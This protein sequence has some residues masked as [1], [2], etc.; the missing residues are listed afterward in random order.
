M[1]ECNLSNSEKI[2]EALE[3]S[4]INRLDGQKID[5]EAV[6]NQ[7]FINS[8][9]WVCDKE[10]LA[11]MLDEG[12]GTIIFGHAENQADFLHLFDKIIL[13][14]CAP[15][16]FLKRIMERK[17]NDFGKDETAQKYLLD[18]YKNFEESMLEK[19][20]IPVSTERSLEE[21]VEILT[22]YF[23]APQKC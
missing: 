2:L 15:E 6:L 19:G 12:K 13:L 1:L 11:K 4:W 7:E 22:V 5:Y 21:V 14:Q 10:R 17:D 23:K 16:T 20:A 3:C 9:M 8:H 18:T